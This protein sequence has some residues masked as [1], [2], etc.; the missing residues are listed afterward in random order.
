MNEIQTKELEKIKSE[1]LGKTKTIQ[2][3]FALQN[4]KK[5]MDD[6][7]DEFS[8]FQGF[9]STFGNIDL[10][11]DIVEKG[12]FNKSLSEKMPLMLWQHNPSKPIGKFITAQE[13]DNG[14]FVVGSLPNSIQLSREVGVMLKNNIIS[15]IY[16]CGI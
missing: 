5:S 10:Q 9:A 13:T 14:L 8:F 12:A 11:G 6:D 1:K 16:T 7:S 4:V 15:W 3:N 2:C